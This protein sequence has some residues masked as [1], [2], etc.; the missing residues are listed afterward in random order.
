MEYRRLGPSDLEISRVGFGCW[1]IG[2]HGYGAVDD[3]VSKRAIRK[4]LDLGINFF[5]TA[6]VYGFG[7]SESVLSEALGEHRH[8]VVIATKFG[9][10]CDSEGKTYRDCSPQNILRSLE[11]SLRRLK[12][13]CIPLYQIHWHDGKTSIHAVMETLERCREAG[14]IRY[15]G[16]CNFPIDLVEAAFSSGDL[17]SVQSLYNVKR[18]KN[19]K[20]MEDCF[21]GH[22]MGVVAYEVLG[23]GLF[24]GKFGTDSKFGDNDTRGRDPEFQDKELKRNIDISRELTE[25][26][27]RQGKSAAQTAIRWVLEKPFVTCALIGAKSPRQVEENVGALGWSLDEDELERLNRLEGEKG[28]G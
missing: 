16:C 25:V 17:V 9:V 6:N 7:R 12:V 19:E 22:Q 27:T 1:A 13:D 15:I 26:G 28:L 3:K 11:E 5:D 14:K 21:H 20:I 18:R 8:Q 2:G 23:R 10:N 24:S 4:A